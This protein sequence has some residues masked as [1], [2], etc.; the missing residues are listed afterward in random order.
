MPR[1]KRFKGLLGEIENIDPE[2]WPEDRIREELNRN[3]DLIEDARM[4]YNKATARIEAVKGD[5]KSEPTPHSAVLF[6]ERGGG[7][8]QEKPFGYWLKVGVAIS[9]PFVI[10]VVILAIFYFVARSNGWL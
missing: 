2:S 3:L 5:E 9:L 1:A 7:Q 4:E 8:D 6:E 10:T